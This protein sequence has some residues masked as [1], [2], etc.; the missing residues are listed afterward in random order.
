M[1]E[2]GIDVTGHVPTKLTYDD[3]LVADV[4]VTMGCGDTCPFVPSTRYEDWPL[5]DPAGKGIETVRR[6]RDEI[7]VRVRDLL[8][9]LLDGR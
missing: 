9:S 4:V 2:V 6:V 3:V 5:E 7:E 1:A 8:A